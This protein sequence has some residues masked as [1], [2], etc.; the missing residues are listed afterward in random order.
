MGRA[1]G[2]F[3]ESA[4]NIWYNRPYGFCRVSGESLAKQVDAFLGF[5][6]EGL[7]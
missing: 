7:L 4:L 3:A 5:T 6:G 2:R 1:E